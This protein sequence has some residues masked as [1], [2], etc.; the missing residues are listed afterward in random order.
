M[1]RDRVVYEPIHTIIQ[2]VGG[3]DAA[4][5]ICGVTHSA[6]YRWMRPREQG[7]LAGDIDIRHLRALYRH[8]EEHALDMP[9]AWL[10]REPEREWISETEVA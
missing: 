2:T 10:L 6:V 3:V 8:A 5:R 1:R 4:A 7:G 9:L